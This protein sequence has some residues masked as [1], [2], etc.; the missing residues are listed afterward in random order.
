MLHL[1][2]GFHQSGNFTANFG[3]KLLSSLH[4]RDC[5]KNLMICALFHS[6][7]S[8]LFCL[9]WCSHI[10]KN[11]LPANHRQQIESSVIYYSLWNLQQVHEYMKPG[12]MAFKSQVSYTT[13]TTWM[14]WINWRTE[15]TAV[16][17]GKSSRILYVNQPVISWWGCNSIL[18][19]RCENYLWVI[20]GWP[21]KRRTE[22]CRFHQQF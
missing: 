15:E 22:R 16:K 20:C 2:K 11:P 21:T 12:D 3:S 5:T 9:Q 19:N 14:H 6:C 1:Y 8:S 4:S 17:W 18:H 13:P 10:K 7:F